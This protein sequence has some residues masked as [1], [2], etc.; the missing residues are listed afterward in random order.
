MPL[1]ARELWF[2]YGKR[3]P[4][5]LEGLSL[6]IEP[7]ERV[8]ILAPSGRGKST[9][10]LLLG[11]YLRPE[12]G[13][14][15]IGGSPLPRK[16]V[17]PVQLIYQHPEEAIDPRWRLRRV[18]KESSEPDVDLLRRLG[19]EAAWLARYP[20]ELS[21]GELQRFCIA[22]ALLSGARY[23]IC[24]EISSMLDVMTQ[25]QLW[26]VVLE[27]AQHHNIGLIAITHNRNLA[28]RIATRIIEL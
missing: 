2:R 14:V 18:L 4:W 15:L 6:K 7:G 3:Q 27:E 19:I 21:G 11:G 23:L 1:E 20:R 26:G 22:R 24:D 13:E 28:D 12:R 16:G 8:A 25:A 9:L 10:G 17:C 5:I